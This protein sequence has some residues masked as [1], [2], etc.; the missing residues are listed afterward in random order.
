[1]VVTLGFSLIFRLYTFAIMAI[2][3]N[4]SKSKVFIQKRALVMGLRRTLWHADEVRQ[5]FKQY[6]DGTGPAGMREWARGLADSDL[7]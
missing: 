5:Q 3:A 6:A 1:M 7:A 4:R 2:R